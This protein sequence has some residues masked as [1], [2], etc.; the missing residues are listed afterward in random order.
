MP[1]DVGVSQSGPVKLHGNSSLL[2]SQQAADHV[3]SGS[4]KEEEKTL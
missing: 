1:D 4:K 2:R 3:C